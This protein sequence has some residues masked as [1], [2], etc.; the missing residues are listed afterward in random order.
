M[1]WEYPETGIIQGSSAT[2][3]LFVAPWPAP[4]E[5]KFCPLLSLLRRRVSPSPS[6]PEADF[7]L[8]AGMIIRTNKTKQNTKPFQSQANLFWSSQR[9]FRI[10]LTQGQGLKH[11]SDLQVVYSDTF[12][13]GWSTQVTPS[14]VN[15]LELLARPLVSCYGS[16]CVF[17]FFFFFKGLTSPPQVTSDWS[18]EHQS[19]HSSEISTLVLLQGQKVTHFQ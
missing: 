17:F 14:W 15:S 4:Q 10:L 6:S 2:Q 8:E 16:D 5:D 9:T 13:P 19:T 12:F 1:S 3:E 7:H 11:P 18:Q